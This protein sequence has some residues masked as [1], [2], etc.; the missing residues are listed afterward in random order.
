[1]K[2]TG[3]PLF[4]EWL[5]ALVRGLVSR[6]P[7]T[8]LVKARHW[9]ASASAHQRLGQVRARR[10]RNMSKERK[11]ADRKALGLDLQGAE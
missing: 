3:Q 2:R 6:L 9:R 7:V 4:Q 1:M 8:M 5:V 11:A 10:S